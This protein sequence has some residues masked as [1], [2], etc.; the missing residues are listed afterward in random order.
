MLV[1]ES[2]DVPGGR[3]AT[4]TMNGFQIDRGFQV[5]QILMLKDNGFSIIRRSILS[6]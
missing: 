6:L 5:Y 4:E 1:F 2:S 3:V